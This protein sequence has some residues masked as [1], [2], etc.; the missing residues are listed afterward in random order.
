MDK[1]ADLIAVHAEAKNIEVKNQSI[2]V[3]MPFHPGARKYFEE[4]GV[5]FSN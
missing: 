2:P 5:K 1:K 3:P 4:Q